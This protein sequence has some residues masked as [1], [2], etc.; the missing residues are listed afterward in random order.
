VDERVVV[1]ID[2][3]LL[4]DNAGAVQGRW[5][6]SALTPPATR[7]Y[8][9]L[10]QGGTP[11]TADPDRAWAIGRPEWIELLVAITDERVRAVHGDNAVPL[12]PRLTAA[13][14]EFYRRYLDSDAS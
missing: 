14:L 13:V 9:V 1:T 5:S 2:A 7:L 3:V 6:P 4:L 11:L 8:D 10:V 12:N